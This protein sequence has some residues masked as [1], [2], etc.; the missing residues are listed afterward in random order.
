MKTSWFIGV[1]MLFIVLSLISGVIEMQ[2]LSGSL[3]QVSIFERLFASPSLSWDMLFA[4][5]DALMFDYAFFA[6]RLADSKV[7]I[8]LVL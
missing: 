3:D 5:W 1:L 7:D 8:I 4:F 6:W 2:Y